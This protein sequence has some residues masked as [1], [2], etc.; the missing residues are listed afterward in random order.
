[1]VQL[2]QEGRNRMD[3]K[4]LHRWVTMSAIGAVCI[5]I[6]SVAA[7]VLLKPDYHIFMNFLSNLGTG[8]VS[9][10]I[11]SVGMVVTAILLATFFSA[12]RPILD[13]RQRVTLGTVSG[14]AASVGLAGVGIFPAGTEPYHT[15][16]AAFFFL[17]AGLAVVLLHLYATE[18]RISTPIS[19]ASGVA[20]VALGVLFVLLER[21]W[22]ENLS[23][24]AFGIWLLAMVEVS[25]RSLSRRPS[26]W[27]PQSRATA[28]R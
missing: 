21:P 12:L 27:P 14:L 5:F 24:V 11:F 9:G 19:R 17:A 13:T 23:V 3:R 6:A 18:E 4:A 8:E 15:F 2:L 16:C 7:S 20:F 25:G 1:M 22:V 28:A 10:P 26:A